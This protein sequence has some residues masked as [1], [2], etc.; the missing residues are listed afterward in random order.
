MWPTSQKVRAP[1]HYF[2]EVAILSAFLKR[3]SDDTFHQ[4]QPEVWWL[5]IS[6]RSQLFIA[7]PQAEQHYLFLPVTTSFVEP[8]FSLVSGQLTK[9]QS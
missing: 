9:K 6:Y 3:I 5:R 1:L 8:V 4:V 2:D 7:S